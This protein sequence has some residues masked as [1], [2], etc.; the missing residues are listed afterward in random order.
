ML[1]KIE[2]LSMIPV[3][4]MT[5]TQVVVFFVIVGILHSSSIIFLAFSIFVGSLACF[6]VLGRKKSDWPCR[7]DVW[8]VARWTCMWIW[9]GS[10]VGYSLYFFSYPQSF[11]FSSG[12]LWFIAPLISFAP[13]LMSIILTMC[14]GDTAL[15]ILQEDEP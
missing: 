14:A 8:S 10:I 11:S 1:E 13:A 2:D 6:C 3:I 15:F 9:I 12:Q 4:V 7:Q 5:L